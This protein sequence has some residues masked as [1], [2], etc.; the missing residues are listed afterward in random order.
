MK[1]LP[2]NKKIP[3]ENRE[4]KV[5]TKEAG[6]IIT[7]C[8]VDTKNTLARDHPVIKRGGNETKSQPTLTNRLG[9][10]AI[11]LLCTVQLYNHVCS[12]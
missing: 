8:T 4:W 11:N 1:N 6:V 3:K 9:K 10:I 7:H 5:G 2:L 12:L